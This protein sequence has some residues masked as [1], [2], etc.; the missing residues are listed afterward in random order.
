MAS[1][2]LPLLAQES[3][4]LDVAV[5]V[6]LYL[7]HDVGGLHLTVL[8]E[9]VRESTLGPQVLLDRRVAPDRQR[10][11]HLAVLGLKDGKDPGLVGQPR[12][13][14]RVTRRRPPSERTRDEDVQ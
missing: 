10:R 1:G 6:G 3:V 14:D 5:G 13:S 2:S 9:E 4:T 11:R 7:G 12:Q 8:G